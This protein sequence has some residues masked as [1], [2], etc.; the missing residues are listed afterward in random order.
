MNLNKPILDKIYKKQEEIV[1]RNIAGDTILVPIKGKLANM[2]KIF[3]LEGTADRIW[4]LLNG[5]NSVNDICKNISIAFDVDTDKAQA[6]TI[7]FI[8]ELLKTELIFEVK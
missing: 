3:S 5:Q 8:D 7:E 4:S 1:T 2:E 6:D